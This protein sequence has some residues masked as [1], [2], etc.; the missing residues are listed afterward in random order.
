MATPPPAAQDIADEDRSI[1]LAAHEGMSSLAS[2]ARRPVGAILAAVAVLWPFV[3]GVNGALAWLNTHWT[4]ALNALIPLAVAAARAKISRDRRY[5]VRTQRGRS[6]RPHKHPLT[7]NLRAAAELIELV[8]G[9]DRPLARPLHLAAIAAAIATPIMWPVSVETLRALPADHQAASALICSAAGPVAGWTWLLTRAYSV[10][11]VRRRS[12]AAIYEIA[13]EYLHYPKTLPP[14]PTRTDVQLSVPHLAVVVTTWKSLTSV[15][16]AAVRLPTGLSVTDEGTWAEFTANLE[17]HEPREEGWRVRRSPRH[18]YALLGPANYP[19]VVVWNGEYEP[20]PLTFVTAL[21]LRTGR[22]LTTTFA[23]AAAHCL[24]AGGTRTGKTSWA[25]I[26]AAQLVRKPMPWDPLLMGTVHIIDPKGTMA[27]RWK[28]RPNVVVSDGSTDVTDS[29]DDDGDPMT[30]IRIMAAHV[31]YI[32]RELDRR[33]RI[34]A[35]YPDAG[36]WVH[37]SEDVKRRERLAP[38]LVIMDEYLDH[39]DPIEGASTLAVKED[40]A[41]AYIRRVSDMHRRK[42]ANVG[43]HCITI[44]HETKMSVLGTGLVRMSP[45]RVLTGN[46]PDRTYYSNMFATRNVP[47]LPATRLDAAQSEAAGEPVSVPIPGRARIMNMAGSPIEPVQV[48]GFGGESNIETL[49]RYVPRTSLRPVNG[50]FTAPTWDDLD[51]SAEMPTAASTVAETSEMPLPLVGPEP[52]PE[53]ATAAAS[54]T[55]VEPAQIFPAGPSPRSRPV[56]AST[57]DQDDGSWSESDADAQV[58]AIVAALVGAIEDHELEDELHVVIDTTER[59]EPVIAIVTTHNSLLV[60]VTVTADGLEARSSSGVARGDD[61]ALEKARRVIER[62]A[63]N[64]AASHATNSEDR[65][66]QARL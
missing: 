11:R 49:D 33:N 56:A 38:L 15:D 62:R 46:P 5:V 25:E 13:A 36:T 47:A 65:E 55:S 27:R 30:G 12:L 59:D 6:V 51:A 52:R 4:Y 16:T 35:Q 18:D 8:L 39:L 41:R 43:Y 19:D 48:L 45:V 54:S 26:V 34:L 23:D 32:D 37:L 2:Q 53:P 29:L 7:S 50:D 22:W 21:S 66:Q 42:Y 31:E 9:V 44:S 1:I 17:E 28:G 60:T 10:G 3:Y 61:E 57:V 63:H 64:R 40:R 24:C 20:D 14:K 58:D